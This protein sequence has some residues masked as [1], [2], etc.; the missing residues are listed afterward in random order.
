[1]ATLFV[2]YGKINMC[3]AD[4]GPKGER[5]EADNQDCM[6]HRNP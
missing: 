5:W 4:M 6:L 2:L 1:M 3:Y